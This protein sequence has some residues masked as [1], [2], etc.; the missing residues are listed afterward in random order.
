MKPSPSD[1]A[2]L[3]SNLAQ[4]SRAVECMVATHAVRPASVVDYDRIAGLSDRVATYSY[5]ITAASKRLA[6]S[7]R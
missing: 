3:E 1:L 2:A 5:R 7:D 6:E 4:L